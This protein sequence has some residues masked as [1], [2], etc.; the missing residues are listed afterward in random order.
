MLG[1][2]LSAPFV[3]DVPE[4]LVDLRV[5]GASAFGQADN[6]RAAFVGCDDPAVDGLGW[7]YNAGYLRRRL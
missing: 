1:P 2:K 7:Q 6:A 4:D 5:C 3:L